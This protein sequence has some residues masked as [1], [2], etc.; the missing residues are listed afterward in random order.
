MIT[1]ESYL[2][3]ILVWIAWCVLHSALI[4]VPVTDHFERV[5]GANFR[6]YRL[7]YNL[8]SI[9]TL[10]VPVFLTLSIQR[11]E[12]VLLAWAGMAET[13]RFFLIGTAVILF[14]SG[15]K[16]YDL[17]HFLGISQVRTRQP[18]HLLK[19]QDVFTVSGVSR[20]TRHPWYLGGIL[21]V[22]S[23]PNSFFPS[24]VITAVIIS[25]Y[26]LVGTMLEEYKL[27][28]HF[29]DTYREYQ[30]D[31]SML[32]PLKWLNRLFKINNKRGD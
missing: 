1:T 6:F 15:G 29:G 14:I 23:A 12:T 4:C 3:L 16:H 7:A 17:S 19:G 27:V 24:T 10:A 22:W 2:L 13:I 26:F 30:R 28:K 20:M 18:T 32:F 31:V 11:S 25:V 9:A 8:I 21:M 5:L